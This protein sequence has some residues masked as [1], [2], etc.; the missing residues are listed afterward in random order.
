MCK[1]VTVKKSSRKL[2]R[3]SCKNIHEASYTAKQNKIQIYKKQKQTNKKKTGKKLIDVI[4]F[5]R[6][7]HLK[8]LHTERYSGHEQL[9][10][11]LLGRCCVVMFQDE[12]SWCLARNILHFQGFQQD[13]K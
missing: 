13:F 4:S 10:V 6:L 3:Y 5:I 2:W 11:F 1:L 9:L 8:Q 7:F 12:S